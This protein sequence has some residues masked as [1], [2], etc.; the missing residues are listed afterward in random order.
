[1]IFKFHPQRLSESEMPCLH[2][3]NGY[4]NQEFVSIS[5]HSSWDQE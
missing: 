2:I 5:E 3:F 1:M 4:I